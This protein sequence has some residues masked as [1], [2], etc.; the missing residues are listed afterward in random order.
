MPYVFS[1]F[2]T[3]SNT[4]DLGLIYDKVVIMKK[5]VIYIWELLPGANKLKQIASGIY[6]LFP[7]SDRRPPIRVNYHNNRTV[8]NGFNPV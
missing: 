7:E 1:Q 2:L 5:Y 6:F 4:E 3:Y 8:A